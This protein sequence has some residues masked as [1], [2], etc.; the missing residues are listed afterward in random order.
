MYYIL[1]YSK[2]DHGLVGNKHDFGRHSFIRYFYAT[3]V[4]NISNT[5]YQKTWLSI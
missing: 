3:I 4:W 5:K 2:A 1:D